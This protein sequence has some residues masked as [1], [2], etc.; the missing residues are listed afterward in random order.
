MAIENYLDATAAYDWRAVYM[1]NLAA[2]LLKLNRCVLAIK[3]PIFK[4]IHTTKH[5]QIL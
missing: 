4:L 2:A 5:P 3:A 1:N